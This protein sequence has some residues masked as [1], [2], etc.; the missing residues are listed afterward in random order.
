M[1]DIAEL[2]SIRGDDIISTLYH[3]NVIK[4]YKAQ[5]CI[6]LTEEMLKAHDKAMTKK[7]ISIDP[8]CLQFTPVDWAKRGAW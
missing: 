5:N 7:K 6:V 1:N 4:Y 8:S 2:T 3:L